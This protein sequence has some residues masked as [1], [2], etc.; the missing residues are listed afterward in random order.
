M[1]TR[2]PYSCLR[3]LPLWSAIALCSTFAAM[4]QAPTGLT[5]KTATSKQVVLSWTGT[6]ASYSVQR[7]PLGGAFATI[8][9]PTTST[10]TDTTI[11]PYTTYQYQV[12]A[13]SSA[14]SNQVTV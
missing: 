13:G 6:A 5:V 1:S 12:V 8:G 7:A 10:F 14:A 3:T 9:S 11:D 2:R 4:A